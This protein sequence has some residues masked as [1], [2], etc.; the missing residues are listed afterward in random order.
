MRSIVTCAP[1]KV[2][3]PLVDQ[4]KD[5]GAWSFPSANDSP[6]SFICSKR[7]NGPAERKCYAAR[8]ALCR[9]C[10]KRKRSDQQF[11]DPEILRSAPDDTLRLSLDA[12]SF[13]SQC[14]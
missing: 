7:K 11:S 8:F 13:F 12:A 10:A 2:P 4:L 1:E 6:S 14:A 5:A 9:C 3:Q